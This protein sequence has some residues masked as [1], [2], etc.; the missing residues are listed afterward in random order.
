VG[1][2]NP[3]PGNPAGNRRGKKRLYMFEEKKADSFLK[4]VLVES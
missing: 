1:V 3:N 4:K 2:C